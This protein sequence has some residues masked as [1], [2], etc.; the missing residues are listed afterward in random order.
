MLSR[1]FVRQQLPAKTE[2]C[3]FNSM[4]V[5]DFYVSAVFHWYFG[6]CTFLRI[7]PFFNIGRT[8]TPLLIPVWRTCCIVRAGHDPVTNLLWN[9]YKYICSGKNEWDS[10]S[11]RHFSFGEEKLVAPWL[12]HLRPMLAAYQ[13]FS[14]FSSLSLK[15][16]LISRGLSLP[17]PTTLREDW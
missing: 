12:Q 8:V 2:K 10:G 9:Q 17:Y 16:G 3:P 6:M 13:N 7:L 5:S 1:F 4:Y 14:R 11:R 15:I